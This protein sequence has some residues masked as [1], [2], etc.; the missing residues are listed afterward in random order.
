ML[1]GGGYLVLHNFLSV[2]LGVS[3]RV[4][5]LRFI[6]PNETNKKLCKNR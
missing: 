4:G 1:I 6:T 2:T 5:L 3:L